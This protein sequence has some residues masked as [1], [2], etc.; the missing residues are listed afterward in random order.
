V[1]GAMRRE[2]WP[3][4]VPRHGAGVW[5]A[6]FCP[7]TPAKTSGSLLFIFYIYLPQ[8]SVLLFASHPEKPL[9]NILPFSWVPLYTR[10]GFLGPSGVSLSKAHRCLNPSVSE[11]M[12]QRLQDHLSFLF[13]IHHTVQKTALDGYAN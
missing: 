2:E 10:A 12:I 5:V 11:P 13:H 7:P 4:E 8:I 3:A 1:V 9:P 6:R